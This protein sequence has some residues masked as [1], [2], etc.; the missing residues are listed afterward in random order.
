MV[1]E[2]YPQASS[3]S[4]N[5]RPVSAHKPAQRRTTAR[6]RLLAAERRFRRR[7]AT[8]PERR[9][10][11]GLHRHGPRR[12]PKQPKARAERALVGADEAFRRRSGVHMREG[13]RDDR[14]QP[15][16][17]PVLG[18][19]AERLLAVGWRHDRS[20]SAIKRSSGRDIADPGND[21]PLSLGKS[22]GA[23]LASAGKP[24]N[25]EPAY[26][27]PYRSKPD[28]CTTGGEETKNSLHAAPRDARASAKRFASK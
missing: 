23:R 26:H 12:G 7:V 24:D 5:S 18:E 8:R 28:G 2:T 20:A 1:P 4:E 19:G 6:R 21:L 17:H 16:G 14:R 22:K 25:H 10:D 3:L 9:L 13:R 27:E 11:Q 15:V